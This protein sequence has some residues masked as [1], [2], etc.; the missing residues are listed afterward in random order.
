MKR[1]EIVISILQEYELIKKEIGEDR[2]HNIDNYIKHHPELT[3]DKLVYNMVNWHNFDRWYNET[4][5]LQKVE[6][7]NTWVTDYDD[8]ACNAILYKDGK[9][10][11]NI[12]E[13]YDES[14]IR[15]VYGD[16]YSA[17]SKE[18]IENSFETLINDDFDRFADLPKI[19]DCSK[20]LVDIYDTVCDSDSSM[21]HID[22]NDWK[23]QYL[24]DYSEEDIEQLQKEI[25]KFNLQDVIG[26]DDGEYKII[27]YSDLQ[28]RFNDDRNFKLESENSYGYDL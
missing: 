8:I 25:I 7:L 17:L 4:I 5:K 23:E 1:G 12:I 22:E 6:I 15:Y 16:Q 20:L 24:D 9:K 2:W 28:M 13:S 27:G 3:F 10:V 21:C 26:I 19:S 18:L 11:A 14:T